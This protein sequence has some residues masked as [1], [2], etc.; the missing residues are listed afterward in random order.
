MKWLRRG[1][2]IV[3]IGGGLV[4]LGMAWVRPGLL[5]SWARLAL[6]RLPAW[7]RLWSADSTDTDERDDDGTEKAS[8]AESGRESF[9]VVRLPSAKLARR[10]GVETATATKERHAH[11][12]VCNA[13]AAYDARHSAEIL[14][15]VTGVLRE[16]RADLGQVVRKGD[17]LAVVD[18]AQ[19]GTSKVQYHTARAAVELARVTYDRTV[20]LT[21]EKAT[22]AK[23]ELE[24]LTSLNQSKAN[25]MDAEQKLRNLG[26]ADAEIARIARA[27]EA[28]NRL[29]VV[30]PIDGTITAWDA[31]P[32]EAVEPT[33]QLFAMADVSRMW[34][35]IDVYESG[36]ASVA[37]DQPVTF[38]ISGTEAPVFSGRVTSVGTEVNPTTRTSRVRAELENPSGRL[39]ANQFGR[40]K[41]QVEAEHEGVVI[42]RAA[43]Q[44][45]GQIE[46]VFLPID[47]RSYRPQLVTIRL[48]ERDDV[49]EV[50][51][52]LETGQRVVT[53]RSYMLKAE[54]FK[55]RL[56]AA[57]ND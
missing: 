49:V 15:R 45:D 54:L 32:G 3:V 46:M 35:W 26:F 27:G 31:T 9:R 14:S 7:A 30:A 12:L 55:N 52:G 56:G 19:I 21:K 36:I 34:L 11:R 48:T 16:V 20:K 25:L 5:D 6:D 23:N 39:R 43:V 38:T 51:K 1:L 37:V 2:V 24:S 41:I 40:A 18:S 44:N 50:V 53:T 22:P 10:F 28:S 13:E 8:E 47:D 4:A 57:D 42:P 17:L 33:T 29:E